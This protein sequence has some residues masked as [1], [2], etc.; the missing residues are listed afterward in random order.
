MRSM[1]R[2]VSCARE[3]VGKLDAERA[4]VLHNHVLAMFLGTGITVYVVRDVVD[5]GRQL[6]SARKLAADDG[7][8]GN[9]PRPTSV[10]ASVFLFPIIWNSRPAAIPLCSSGV[11]RLNC[12]RC[13]GEFVRAIPVCLLRLF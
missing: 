4:A 10:P 8:V 12:A 11:M 3:S 5:A 2:C 6:D 1:A 9:E 13:A 7:Q